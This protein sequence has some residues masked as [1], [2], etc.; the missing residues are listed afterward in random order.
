MP[1]LD[2][3]SQ[4]PPLIWRDVEVPAQTNSVR[5]EQG[6]VEHRQHGVDGGHQENTG[7]GSLVATFRIPFRA[8]VFAYPDLY[9]TRFRDFWNACLD[10]STGNLAHPEFGEFDVKVASFSL[11]V[12]PERRDGYDV[13]VEFRETTENDITAADN[14]LGPIAEAI[15][16]AQAMEGE[17]EKISPVPEYDDGEFTDPL[18]ALKQLEG[19]LKLLQMSVGGKLAKVGNTINAINDMIDT[20]NKATQPEAWGVVDAL[21]GIEGAL[22]ETKETLS[23]DQKKIDF[24]IAPKETQVRDAAAASGMDL[25]A[26]LTLNPMLAR[27]KTIQA[28]ESYFVQV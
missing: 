4:L 14:P 8:G 13:D 27:A 5:F 22:Q 9:P 7:R 21:K 1:D 11:S 16:I 19:S 24:V 25:S 23:P 2:I 6:L 18:T 10:G 28:G 3:L 26:F 20:A 12:V 15:S 17:P